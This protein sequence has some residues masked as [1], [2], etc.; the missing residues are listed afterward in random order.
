MVSRKEMKVRFAEFLIFSRQEIGWLAIAAMV[1]GFIFSFR[2][3][4]DS[5]FD[6]VLGFVH[7]FLLVIICMFSFLVRF[8][9][10][11]YYALSM[12]YLAEFK[13]WWVGLAISLVMVFLSMGKVPLVLLGGVSVAFMSRQR[14]G[15]FRYGFSYRQNAEIA[16]WGILGNLILAF[17]FSVGL[18]FFPESY[19]FDKA[20][21][22]NITM[23]FFA[24]L[25]LVQ[26]DGLSIF[27]GSR[28]MF[29]LGFVM[30]IIGA[31]LIA[32]QTKMGLLVVGILGV[33]GLVVLNLIRSN[34]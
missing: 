20:M 26:M 17:L 27:F 3:W 9:L 12:G 4:G 29:I 33:A 5:E 21:W 19:L 15:E 24:F 13:V 1:V 6:A 10:Q 31:V 18:Y 34:K 22:I 2:D 28:T 25:P 32:T 30:F 7:F 23:G 14:I 11:K 8:T 16:F